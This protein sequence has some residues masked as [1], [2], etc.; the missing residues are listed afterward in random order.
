MT[1]NPSWALESIAILDGAWKV[2]TVDFICGLP[3]SENKEMIMVVIDKFNKFGHFIPLSHPYTMLEVA[4]VFL[5][6]YLQ[7]T[8]LTKQDH[9]R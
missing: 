1:L 9:Y 4:R 2:I 7:I 3:K 5:K 6:K 8:W